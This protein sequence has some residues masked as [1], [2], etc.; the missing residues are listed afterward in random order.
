MN[1][2]FNENT[3]VFLNGKFTP[4]TDAKTGVYDQSLHYGNAVF[5]GIRAYHTSQ[6]TQIFKAREH[7]QRL[8][9]SAEKMYMKVPYT[10]EQ[11]ISLTYQL[12]EHNH[13]SSAYI[14][15]L[16]FAGPNMSLKG[17]GKVSL[18]IAVWEWGNYLGNDVLNVMIS[19][20]QRPHPKAFFMEA[21]VAGHYVNSILAS[22]EAQ[23]EGY[24]D[25]LLLDN[26]GNVAE[27]PGANFFYEKN[28]KLYTS[29]LGHILPGIT[30]S[31]IIQ[32]A[33]QIGI[34]VIEK[35]SK[36]E[37]VL[38]A[39]G[40]FFTSTAL[41]V[42]GIRSINSKT[43]SKNWEDTLGYQLQAL[44]KQKVLLGEYESYAII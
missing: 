1:A 44:Y 19:S 12:L 26:E 16:V 17:A 11:L 30:R 7:Y 25:A 10:I 29:P 24:D 13:L 8:L 27:G 22:T 37:E 15:P 36:P 40:A 35:H 3:I 5:E 33:K 23:N 41:E 20:F 32:L 38:T 39:D 42:C 43:L 21:K 28:G 34:E 31:T 14:R 18:M 4:A 9:N 6:G 2:Y